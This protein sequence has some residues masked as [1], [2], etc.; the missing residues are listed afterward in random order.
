M[1]VAVLLIDAGLHVPVMPLAD[2]PGSV[3]TAAPEQ[4]V[5]EFP[6]ENTGVTFGLIV[7][8]NVVVVAL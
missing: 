1:P 7:T 6:N 3:G 8:V 4:I 5:N 2:V